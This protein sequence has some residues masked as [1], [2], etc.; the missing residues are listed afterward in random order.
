MTSNTKSALVGA[1]AAIAVLG[2]LAVLANTQR[3]THE[4]RIVEK[5]RKTMDR[6]D[7]TAHSS[8]SGL[9]WKGSWN[10]FKGKLK[11][12]FGDLTDDDLLYQEGKEDELYG[13]LQKKWGKTR[14]EIERIFEDLK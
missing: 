10:E 8:T 7:E 12:K 2:G 9:H 14:E 11:Q 5:V 1:G 13:R 6:I 4:D 3:K